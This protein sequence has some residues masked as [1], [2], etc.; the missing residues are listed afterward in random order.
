MVLTGSPAF[1][2]VPTGPNTA[3]APLINMPAVDWGDYFKGR[4]VLPWS[5]DQLVLS[6]EFD[7]GTYD[8]SQTQFRILPGTADWIV[9][10]FPYQQSRILVLY[11]KS[12]HLVLLDGNSL[13]IA[14]AVE[15]TRN[16]GCVARKTVV[17]CGPYI[18]WLSDLGVIRLQIGLEL[19]LTSTTAPLSDP[20]Q[21]IIDLHINV[22]QIYRKLLDQADQQ[23]AND[24]ARDALQ[25]AYDHSWQRQQANVLELG[26]DDLQLPQ[27]QAANGSQRGTNGPSQA[28]HDLDIHA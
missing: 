11:R 17:N 7:A 9:A 2:V 24:G 14:Q 8:P 3:G 18:L 19:N 4:F 28:V 21:N 5:R 13:A 26:R 10:A 23:A 6:D 12:V 22:N 20:I 27:K 25:T 1:V 15:V 16:F